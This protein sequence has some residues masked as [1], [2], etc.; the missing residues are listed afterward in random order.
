MKLNI[1]AK[2]L[3]AASVLVLAAGL[4][5]CKEDEYTSRGD[6]FQPRFMTTFDNV[7]SNLNDATIGWYDVNDAVSYTFQL[8]S[9]NYFQNL[10]LEMETEEPYVRLYDLPYGQRF[11]VRV[12]SN[13]ANAANNSHWATGN[14]TTEPR[15]AFD[16]I[17][18][19]VSKTE[20]TDNTAIIRWLVS[21]ANPVDSFA[22]VPTT[23]ATAPVITGYLTAEQIAAGEMEVTGLQRS[24]LYACDLFD[25]SK[26]R[27][28]DKPYNQVK[29]RT[30]GPA[31]AT[32]QVEITDNL[33]EILNANN[34]DPDIPE[35]AE[36]EL[37][38]GTTYTISPFAI[39]KGFSLVGPEEGDKPVLIMNGTWRF[40]DN[41][42]ITM[43][44][45]KNVEVRNAAVNQYFMNCGGSYSVENVSFTNVT[46]RN[47]YRGFW[48]HQ[49]ANTKYIGALEIDNCW[50]DQCGWQ[51]STY[52]TFHFASAGKDEIGQYDQIMAI[53]IRN[54]TFS[55][56]GYKQD[57]TWGWGNLIN[58]ATTSTPVE[59]TVENVTFYDFCVNNRLIDLTNTEHSTITI[60]S[61]VIASPMGELIS[62]GSGPSTTYDNNYTT[63]DYP[64]GGSRIQAV[65]LPQR[66]ADIFSDPDNGDLS[67]KDLSSPIYL[68]RAGDPR[69]L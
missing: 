19:G 11:Y 13:A 6:L 9:D 61:T 27:Q 43:F 60:R 12:R 29:F 58:H 20:I 21:P 14:F 41:A 47:V 1:F 69:W 36:Y 63:A 35:G 64:N 33:S 25:T 53:T 37:L 56:G 28:Q 2:S 34:I 40:A 5:G 16:H 10:I 65:D 42:V 31:A 66:A 3:A 67:L 52:G 8:F 26:P 30:T 45:L 39:G 7:V 18:Q 46:F 38:A 23:D 24:T 68:N 22:I 51:G 62:A 44:E 15:P 59:L 32:I 55:R 17:V 54:T 48:R 4:T 57:P 50:F 49:N